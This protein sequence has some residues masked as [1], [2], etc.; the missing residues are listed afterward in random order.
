MAPS[1]AVAAL[2]ADLRR[3]ATDFRRSCTPNRAFVREKS[4]IRRGKA[5]GKPGR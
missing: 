2:M 5:P 3:S 1:A 4:L